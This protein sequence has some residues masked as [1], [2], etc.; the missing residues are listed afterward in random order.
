ML[1]TNAIKP[2]TSELNV[3]AFDDFLRLLL[4]QARADR[5]VC[6]DLRSLRFIDLFSAI[7]LL[8]CSKYIVERHGCRVHLELA[9]DGACDFLP[10]MGFLSAIPPGVEV[11]DTFGP[12]RLQLE[13]ALRGTNPKFLELTP[14]SS[15]DV[16]DAILDKLIRILHSNLRYPKHDA[17]DMAIA[18]SEICMNVLDH[19]AFSACGF[20]AMQVCRGNSGRFLQFVVADSGSGILSTLTKNPQYAR[21]TSD[22]QAIIASTGLG[23]SQFSDSSMR[24]NGL[25]QLLHVMAKH[26][27]NVHIRSGTG[28]VY[29][30]AKRQEGYPFEVPE[31]H[32]VQI[33]LRFPARTKP[34][35]GD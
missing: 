34:C 32:G 24:G 14:L 29:W 12:A 25:H 13:E 1:L 26:G 4:A 17:L 10:R 11:S 19:N 23:V 22:K 30:D 3:I 28:R 33:A 5:Q 2:N 6:I 8:H 18:F 16:V 27:G 7:A 20:A 35:M 9:D 21:L 31:M 15:R